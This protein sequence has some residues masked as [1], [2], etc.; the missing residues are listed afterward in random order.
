MVFIPALSVG[1]NR[2]LVPGIFQNIAFRS[3]DLLR[4]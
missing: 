2:D 4:I 1:C 3:A